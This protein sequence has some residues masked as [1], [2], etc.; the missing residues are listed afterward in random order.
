MS[1]LRAIVERYDPTAH[2]C[3]VRPEG[4]PG[5]LWTGVAVAA[6]VPGELVQPER[7]VLVQSWPDVGALVVA[8]YDAPPA[9]P[10]SWTTGQLDTPTIVAPAGGALVL[11]PTLPPITVTLQVPAYL[12]IAFQVNAVPQQTRTWH[13]YVG[14][15]ID[16]GRVAPWA[17]IDDEPTRWQHRSGCKRS[18]DLYDPGSY[19]LTLGYT[20]NVAGDGLMLGQ[21]SLSA[22]ALPA[23]S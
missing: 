7:R 16:G 15:C 2:T 8:P 19:T 17:M 6:D 23:S 4:H 20:F 14:P 18:A 10:L 11:D 1:L 3:D 21:R 12:W 5:A 22:W 13:S 9:Y